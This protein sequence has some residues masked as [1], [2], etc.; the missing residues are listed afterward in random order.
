MSLDLSGMGGLQVLGAS[1]FT[2]STCRAGNGRMDVPRWEYTGKDSRYV[3]Y[4]H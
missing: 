2:D 3:F 4:K 1:A